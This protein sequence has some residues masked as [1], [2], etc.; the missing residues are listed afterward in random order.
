MFLLSIQYTAAIIIWLI[1]MTGGF[2]AMF[3]RRRFHAQHPFIHLAEAFAGGIFLGA[4]LFHML[5]D[6]Q[7]AFHKVLPELKYP[8]A[9]LICAGGF[10]LLLILEQVTQYF[11]QHSPRHSL[12]TVPLLVTLLISIHA[13]S[14]GIALGV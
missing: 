9:N 5:P 10:C 4:A 1:T 14:E 11:N 2:L 13:V 6:A 3:L 12:N 7:I 8:L